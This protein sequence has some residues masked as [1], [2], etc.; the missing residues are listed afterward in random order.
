MKRKRGVFPRACLTRKRGTSP[1]EKRGGKGRN[2]K[3][4]VERRGASPIPKTRSHRKEKSTAFMV[5][6]KGGMKAR[7]EEE[8]RRGG[9]MGGRKNLEP[10]KEGGR[11]KDRPNPAPT[12]N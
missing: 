12:G 5:V 10:I 7:R 6:K 11:W 9:K 3:S 2:Q 8:K 1:R 4:S